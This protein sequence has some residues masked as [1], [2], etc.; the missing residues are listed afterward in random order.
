MV[1]LEDALNPFDAFHRIL[2]SLQEAALDGTR[3]PAASGLIDG[4]LG[5]MRNTVVIGEGPQGAVRIPPVP[6]RPPALAVAAP[7]KQPRSCA[8]INAVRVQVSPRRQGA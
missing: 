8:S 5:T 6:D 7:R 2:T 1:V 3:W 4:G